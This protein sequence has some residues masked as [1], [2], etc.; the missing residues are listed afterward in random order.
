MCLAWQEHSSLSSAPSQ[1]LRSDIDGESMRIPV[2]YIG[3]WDEL[4]SQA[5][6]EI[7][8]YFNVLKEH[9]TGN[10]DNGAISR[11][12]IRTPDLCVVTYVPSMARTQLPFHCAIATT[13]K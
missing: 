8:G 3:Y 11:T 6:G 5:L 1:T 4:L 2:A 12:R 7:I 9:N 10:G 13:K